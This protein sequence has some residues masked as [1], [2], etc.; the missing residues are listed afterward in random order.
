MELFKGITNRKSVRS[1]TGEMISEGELQRIL[2][3]GQSAPIAQGKFDDIHITILSNKNGLD[4]IESITGAAVGQKGADF[5]H[6]APCFVL[7]SAKK[8]PDF[9]DV[10][11]INSAVIMEN[12]L[13]AAVD[14]GIGACVVQG[15]VE[16]LKELPS[17]REELQ[18]PA[19]FTPCCG[20]V[21]GK[22]EEEYPERQVN[23]EKYQID[24]FAE[25]E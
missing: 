4:M 3:A 11:V 10:A 1:Y 6:G 8:D 20:F 25:Q 14:R 22:T 9:P 7:I 12:M 21:L 15:P 24:W 18:I 23:G 17:M 19:A 5:F 2:K 13:L 16:V